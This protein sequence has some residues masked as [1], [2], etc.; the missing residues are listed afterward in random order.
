VLLQQ[1]QQ[2]QQ[3]QQLFTGHIS[4]QQRPSFCAYYDYDFLPFCSSTWRA[5]M[6]EASLSLFGVFIAAGMGLDIG[7][8]RGRTTEHFR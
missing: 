6:Y 3:Q 5:L 2:Q 7:C 8:R 4:I 1:Q